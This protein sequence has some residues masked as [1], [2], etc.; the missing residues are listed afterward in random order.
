MITHRTPR[1]DNRVNKLIHRWIDRLHLYPFFEISSQ[2][3]KKAL[4]ETVLIAAR[5]VISD[6]RHL[7]DNDKL[8]ASFGFP[9]VHSRNQLLEAIDSMILHPERRTFTIGKAVKSIGTVIHH[10]KDLNES[11]VNE[12][13]RLLMPLHQCQRLS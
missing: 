6:S 13:Y 1:E 7:K 5:K 3:E 4:E 11:Y 8:G 9:G 2:A 10:V 12:I